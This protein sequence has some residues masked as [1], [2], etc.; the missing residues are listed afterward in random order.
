[1]FGLWLGREGNSFILT[2]EK[3][4]IF[5]APHG[6][7]IRV[8]NFATADSREDAGE[9]FLSAILKLTG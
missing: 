9:Y 8:P 2:W 3:T 6:D 1:M 5:T 4:A 7:A